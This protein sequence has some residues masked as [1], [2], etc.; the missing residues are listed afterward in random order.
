MKTRIFS[1]LSLLALLLLSASPEAFGQKKLK[2]VKM[3]KYGIA[4]ANYSGWVKVA[5]DSFALIDDKS[6]VDGF[7]PVRVKQ[8]PV[9][10][11]IIDVRCYGLR[12]DNDALAKNK[13]R[14]DIDCEDIT[15]VPD[16]NT[17][18]ICSEYEQQVNEY[19]TEGK[20]TGR[21]LQIPAQF[22][23]KRINDNAGFESVTYNARTSLFW[24]TT[25]GPLKADSATS[26]PLLRL[27]SFGRDLR[28]QGQWFYEMDLPELRPGKYY[29]H[30]VSALL[31]LDD[32]RLL[33][34]ER[35]LTVPANYLGSKTRTKVYCV[36]PA[37]LPSV[38]PGKELA[39]LMPVKCL[40]KKPVF[41][42]D[43]HIRLGRLNYG[44]YEGMA[45]GARL[46]DG[47]QTLLLICDSQAGAGNKFYRLKDYIKVVVLPREVM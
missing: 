9:T 41:S 22:H 8:N 26:R 21:R 16:W 33:V 36:T 7:Y 4:P 20:R 17:Y 39:E 10:G 40:E 45:L 18:F 11:K 23:W 30:G 37:D 12:G 13:R 27:Q 31:A 5:P 2:P 35:E 25:E 29:A 34:L 38:E 32:G 15:Y 44:N 6:R 42:F 28:P 14:A 46:A 43:T 24:V 19:D 3:K 1:F 47:R